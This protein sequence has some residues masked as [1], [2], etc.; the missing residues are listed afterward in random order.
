MGNADRVCANTAEEINRQIDREIEIRVREYSHRTESEIT[1]RINELD[2]EWD[3]ERLLRDQCR[4]ACV[5]GTGVPHNPQPEMAN[6]P[7]RRFTVLISICD[8]RLVSACAGIPAA[9]GSYS[10]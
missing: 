9:W 4:R 1:R 6:C 3:M 10:R 7:E 2:H 8:P 5:H